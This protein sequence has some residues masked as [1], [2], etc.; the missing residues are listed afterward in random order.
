MT[1]E[2]QATFVLNWM[3]KR[4]VWESKDYGNLTEITVTDYKI[5][6]FWIPE[7]QLRA[8]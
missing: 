2:L 7:I 3:D 4:A 8:M 5:W 6:R 1:T